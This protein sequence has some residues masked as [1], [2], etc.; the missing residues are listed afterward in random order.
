MTVI[1]MWQGIDI[2]LARYAFVLLLGSLLVKRARRFILDWIPFL[3]IIISYDFLR[4][5]VVLLIPQVHYG[6]LIQ[7]DFKIFNQIA[8]L[9][10]QKNFFHPQH[11]TW[12]DFV[13]TLIYFSHYVA[14]VSFAFLLWLD[15]KSRFREFVTGIS[16]LSYGGWV[17]YILFP[18]AAPWLAAEAGYLPGI[19]K[20]MDSTL[21]TIF[22]QFDFLTIYQ[23]LNPNPI[24]SFPSMHAAYAFLIFLFSLRYFKIKGLLVLPYVLAIWIS[25][26]YLGE[27]YVIDVVAGAVYA[28][29]FFL[30]SKEILH[31]IN[32]Q[33][34]FSKVKIPNAI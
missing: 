21:K 13:A 34:F 29:F 30:I 11:L 5:L 15:N 26:I 4:G 14:W 10:L 19:V 1:M 33:K 23:N 28:S 18:S 20:V 32:W 7:A 3:F 9:T 8:A 16:L 6:E 31:R 24:S 25:I 2:L 12:Y 17:T 27:H 22:G